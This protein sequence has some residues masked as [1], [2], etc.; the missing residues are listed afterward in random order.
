MTFTVL[1]LG[2]GVQST[3][4]LYLVRDGLLPRPD[5][6]IFAD[7]GSEMP[8]TMTLVNEKLVPLC[9]QMGIPLDIVKSHLGDSLD[10]FYKSKSVIPIIGIRHCTAK[11]KIRPIR[12]KVRE[13]VGKKNGVHLADCWLGITTD[14]SQRESVSDV[15]WLQNKFPLLE[16]GLSR[17]DCIEYL[18]DIGIEV[19]KSGCFMCCYNSGP[20]WVDVKANHPELWQRALEL[21]D[22]YFEKRP[23]R[24]RGLRSDGKRLRDPL[25]RFEQSK[26]DS[27]G[28]FI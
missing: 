18:N 20:K 16:L 7:T 9:D 2:G 21:E 28:C 25:T 24:Y 23:E 14:E 22:E 5:V 6:V 12:R 15:K 27:G 26:C 1:S 4:M 3:A 19:V 8:A 11:F 17:Q 10:S 13:Y